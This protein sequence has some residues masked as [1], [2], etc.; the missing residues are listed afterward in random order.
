MQTSPPPIFNAASR[1][2]AY[3]NVFAEADEPRTTEKGKIP[4]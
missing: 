4:G 3:G 2:C 1:T